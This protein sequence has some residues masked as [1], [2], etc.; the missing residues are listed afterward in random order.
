MYRPPDS[1]SK[2]FF[3]N[4]KRLL[5][6][7]TPVELSRLIICM[8]YNLDLVKYNVHTLTNDFLELN[9][10]KQLLPTITKPTRV[11]RNTATLIDNIIVGRK[12]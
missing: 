2:T 8:D 11:T 7:F 3:K 1:N 10:E 4:Y 12:F 5:N 9:L 6:R